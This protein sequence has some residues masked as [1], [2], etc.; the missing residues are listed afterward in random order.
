[1]LADR[2]SMVAWS[3]R[4]DPE[5]DSARWHQRI[6]ALAEASAYGLSAFARRLGLAGHGGGGRRGGNREANETAAAGW[7]RSTAGFLVQPADAN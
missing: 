5:T 6:R 1:M 3:G 4:T 2:H 7:L